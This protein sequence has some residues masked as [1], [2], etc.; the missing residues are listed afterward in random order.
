MNDAFPF[1]EMPGS[2][3]T[4]VTLEQ[5]YEKMQ[6]Q[7]QLQELQLQEGVRLKSYTIN[8]GA[9][10]NNRIKQHRAN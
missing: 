10:E 4:A 7:K 3:Q 9:S 6:Q 8:V 2:I 1:K 5:I